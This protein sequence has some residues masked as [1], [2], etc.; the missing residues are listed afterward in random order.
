MCRSA[1]RWKK[2]DLEIYA[3]CLLRERLLFRVTP[4]SLTCEENGTV[5]PATLILE[6]E[7][8]DGT[9]CLVPIRMTSDLLETNGAATFYR[10]RWDRLHKKN[11]LV[12]VIFAGKAN[13]EKVFILNKCLCCL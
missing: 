8:R 4:S 10:M 2:H 11:R 7:R 6:R 5:L 12:D 9:R 13:V 1:R 3:R